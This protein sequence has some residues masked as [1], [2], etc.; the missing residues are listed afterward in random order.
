M[1]TIVYI[2]GLKSSGNAFDYIIENLEPHIAITI[3]YDSTKTLEHIIKDIKTK[4]PKEEFHL[5]C[6]S[7]GGIIG[8]NIAHEIERVL[9]IATISS[10]VGGIKFATFGK[11][12]FPDVIL[13]KELKITSKRV[14]K[15]QIPNSIPTISFISISGGV[16]EI[17]MGRNDSVVTVLSQSMHPTS[18]KVYVDADHF[19]SLKHQKTISYLNEFL[20]D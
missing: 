3:N 2:H 9:S 19:G 1:K 20:F 18:T 6:H 14:L 10:P 5:V 11:F 4:L 8:L 13:F 12:V 7:L 16:N 17:L 15:A